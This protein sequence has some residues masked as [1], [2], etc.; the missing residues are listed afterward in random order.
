MV[1]SKEIAIAPMWKLREEE[2]VG[3][4]RQVEDTVKSLRATGRVLETIDPDRLTPSVT[5]GVTPST[6]LI[7]PGAF[8]KEYPEHD[9]QGQRIVDAAKDWGINV[10][11]L[12]TPSF[13]SPVV[14]GSYIANW[15]ARTDRR[16][17]MLI[18]LSK[19][20]SDA[21]SFFSQPS[22]RPLQQQIRSWVSIGGLLYGSPIVNAIHA[23]TLWRLFISGL[24]RINGYRYTD[25]S[26]LL[27][28]D[29]HAPSWN[30]CGALS[31]PVIHVQSV[32][33]Y[34]DLSSGLAIRAVKRAFHYGVSDGG[35]VL[36]SDLARYEGSLVLIEKRD[37]YLRDIPVQ[38][39][40]GRILYWIDYVAARR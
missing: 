7:V 22:Y 14:G 2:V 16:D 25:L 32:P 39:L 26:T 13:C 11:V 1:W 10:C 31:I 4:N 36:L 12:D 33:R 40:V 18:S 8:A 30:R 38:A 29:A 20:S 6:I 15:L 34:E 28:S 3:Y 23:R 17:V 35:G 5:R 27:W 21:A 37:H 24:L 19:G 9:A